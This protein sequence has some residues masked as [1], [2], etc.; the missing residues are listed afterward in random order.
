MP[1]TTHT[2]WPQTQLSPTKHDGTQVKLH[3]I[4]AHFYKSTF[5]LALE[6]PKSKILQ[7]TP[8]STVIFLCFSPFP[9]SFL[10]NSLNLLQI[11]IFPPSTFHSNSLKFSH[12][13]LIHFP[14]NFLKLSLS[15]KRYKFI[16]TSY[17]KTIIES[18]HTQSKLNNYQT[19]LPNQKKK[20]TFF[21]LSLSIWILSL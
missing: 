21:S 20:P 12:I 6:F 8:H 2:N 18:H 1:S 19:L 9:S 10:S 14:S 17:S 13:F 5:P 11:L 15:L 4:R 7:N 16:L 3:Q